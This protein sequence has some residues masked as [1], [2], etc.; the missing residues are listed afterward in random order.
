M[1]PALPPT[2][3]QPPQRRHWAQRYGMAVAL[4]VGFIGLQIVL[5]NTVHGQP[6][7]IALLAAPLFASWFGGWGPGALATV[8]CAFVGELLL[9]GP[10]D[11]LLIPSDSNEW[12]RLLLFIGYGLLFSGFNEGRLRSLRIAAARQ[13]NLLRAQQELALR[14][15]RMRETL[16]ASPAGMIVVNRD[17]RIELVNHQAERMFGLPREQLVGQCIDQLVPERVR[18]EHAANRAEFHAHPTAR[19]MG[20]GRELWARRG[21]G[22]EFPVEIGLTPLQGAS[23]GLVLAS[24]IDISSRQEAEHALQESAERFR[25]LADHIPQLAWMAAADGSIT[26]YNQRWF[27]FTGT[28][29][30]DMAGWGWQRIHHPDHVARV[31]EKFRR[32]LQTGE[33]WEDTFPL[34]GADGHYRWFLSRAFPIRD[35]EGRIRNWFGTNTDVTAQ[36][37]AE[38]ALRETDRRKDE[39]IAVLAHEL[40]NPLAPV[41]SAVDIMRRLDPADPRFARTREVIGRQVAHMTRLI[42]D[43][44]DVSRIARGKLALRIARC[45]QGQITR[46]TAEDYRASLEANGL[47]LVVDTPE[48]PIWVD[49]DAV[50]LAQMLGNLLNNAGRFSHAG[51]LITVE[52]RADPL[53]RTALMRVTDTGIGI[54]REL[55]ARLFN[56]FEQAAQDLSRSRGGLGLGL[57]LTKGLAELHGGH[58]EAASPGVNQGATFTLFL[59]LAVTAVE[60]ASHRTGAGRRETP[61]EAKTQ[62]LRILVVEDNHDAAETLGE[63]LELAGYQVAVCHDG[64]AGIALA[65]QLQPDVVISDLGLPGEVDG[66]Q[67]A[68][69]LRAEPQREGLY[70]IA[71]SGYADSRARA[72]SEAAGFDEHLPKPPDIHRLELLLERLGATEAGTEMARP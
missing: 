33:P 21:D 68:R 45:D 12:V 58:I 49:G 60:P 7:V 35:A 19:A 51:G 20:A 17:G 16:E 40:R 1:V 15:Q 11:T 66:Y 25:A 39:F 28:D 63:L 55:L 50:R 53:A 69:R 64:E 13:E 48:A 6:P 34:R 38:E 30:E 3:A 59:P 2:G 47:R 43:L 29:F 4:S 32:H 36:R 9:G 8:F 71:L 54:G 27:D 24:V 61:E 57:A 10:G 65:G 23:S 70:L 44:L 67:L 41:R 72:R 46:V 5:R 14:E 62:R 37:E 22:S 31:T 52:A 26:W 56:P 42:D 18:G